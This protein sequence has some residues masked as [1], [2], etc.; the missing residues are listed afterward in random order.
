[1][2]EFPLEKL[3]LNSMHTNCTALCMYTVVY[4]YMWQTVHPPQFDLS[5]VRGRDQEREGWVEGDPV[6]SSVV[7]LTTPQ[8]TGTLRITS[9]QH[10]KS[11]TILYCM[12]ILFPNASVVICCMVS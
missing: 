4:V 11:T 5:V 7:S 6:D 10:F 2:L 8:S 9:Q 12:L 3:V 1:M